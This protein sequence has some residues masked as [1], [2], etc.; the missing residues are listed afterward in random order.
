[1]HLLSTEALLD[2]RHCHIF[3]CGLC[4]KIAAMSSNTVTV[5]PHCPCRQNDTSTGSQCLLTKILPL[6]NTPPR[7]D[8]LGSANSSRAVVNPKQKWR[9]C[10][11]DDHDQL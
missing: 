11:L 3:S 2:L 8:G 9:A 7:T 5:S 6:R 4:R 10:E 1:M